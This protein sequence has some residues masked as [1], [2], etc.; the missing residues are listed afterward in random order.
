LAQAVKVAPPSGNAVTN[1]GLALVDVLVWASAL[2]ITAAGF[3]KLV[4][5]TPA[6]RFLAGLHLPP[7][8]LAVRLVALVEIAVGL[9]VTLIGGRASPAAAAI[10]FAGFLAA[11]VGHRLRTGRSTVSC[12]CFGSTAEVPL[13]PHVAALAVVLGASVGA[14]VASRRS[15]L[16]VVTSV[17]PGQAVLLVALLALVCIAAVGFSTAGAGTAGPASTSRVAPAGGPATFR[18]FIGTATDDPSHLER[19]RAR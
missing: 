15:L 17:A 13:A 3:L 6:A 4:N 16:D 9:A 7:S 11:L 14:A 1:F 8:R 10:L 18:T 5:P 19:R 12:G 2:I